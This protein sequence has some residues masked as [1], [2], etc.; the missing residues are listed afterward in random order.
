MLNAL[1]SHQ[2]C[3]FFF[4]LFYIQPVGTYKIIQHRF[5]FVDPTLLPPEQLCVWFGDCHNQTDVL[6]WD[7]RNNCPSPRG[8]TKSWVWKP[9]PFDEWQPLSGVRHPLWVRQGG[10][11]V[12][13]KYFLPNGQLQIV[14]DC[15]RAL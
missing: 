11:I 7:L 4:V 8:G 3:N 13:P 9:S 2:V 10:G 1:I 12:G 14:C 5:L 15:C 6:P